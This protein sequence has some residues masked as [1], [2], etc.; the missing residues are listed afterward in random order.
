MTELLGL[1]LEQGYRLV[2]VLGSYNSPT[3]VFTGKWYPAIVAKNL[4]N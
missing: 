2:L 4:I 1:G 3:A